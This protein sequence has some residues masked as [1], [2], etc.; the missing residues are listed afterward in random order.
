MQLSFLLTAIG[1]ALLVIS[2]IM[3]LWLRMHTNDLTGERTPAVLATQRAQ[4]GLQRSLASLRGW[5]ALGG[6]RFRAE[7]RQAWSQ[8]IE[9]AFAEIQQFS[10]S[11][12]EPS[13]RERLAAIS[14]PL[15][16]LKE[17]QWWVE[18][19]AQT[20]GNQPAMELL[21]RR[22]Q[23]ISDPLWVLIDDLATESDLKQPARSRVLALQDLA[24]FRRDFQIADDSLSRFVAVDEARLE[25]AFESAISRAE[26]SLE[27]LVNRSSESLGL[28]RDQATYLLQEFHWYKAFAR[29]AIEARRGEAWNVA[30]YRMKTETIP[31][32]VEVTEL[33]STLANSQAEMMRSDTQFVTLAGNT[34]IIL[35]LALILIMA[36]LAYALASYRSDQ[37][38]QPISRLSRATMELAEGRLRRDLPITTDDELGTLT[39]SFNQM[40]V[41]LQESEAALNQANI[42]L[43]DANQDLERHNRFVRSTFGRYLSDDIVANLLD[44]PDGLEI[45]GESRCVTILMADLRGFT[46]LAERLAPEQVVSILN[47]YLGTMVDVITEYGG[48]IDEFLGDAILVIFGAPV[49]TDDHPQRAVAC[50]FA[51]QL[52]MTTV[53]ERNYRDDLP[54]IEMGVG[55]NTGNVVVGNI[56]SETRAKY[57]VVGSPVN[58]TSRIESFTTGGQILISEATKQAVGPILQLGEKLEI[59]AKGINEPV[60][61]HFVR[62]IGGSWNLHLPERGEALI[63]LAQEIP[64]RF[65]VLKGKHLGGPLY[66]GKL[67]RLS[68]R[69]GEFHSDQSV[70][71]LSD[72]KFEVLDRN[73]SN[74]LGELYAKV[75]GPSSETQAG[76]S[77]VFTSISP[78]LTSLFEHLIGSSFEGSTL[79]DEV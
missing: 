42:D 55:V 75:I 29:R 30:L 1:A 60:T 67:V 63:R 16:E 3:V 43:S 47:H 19:V 78:E 2:T 59:E 52:A 69:S 61:V 32:T 50:A 40:R 64:V 25:R 18:D 73:G 12:T 21:R 57:G 49:R 15:V 71:P 5:V 22:V 17:S 28:S 56:G 65:A 70:A 13:D 34:A 31:L 10:K 8:Q 79:R 33:L 38:T 24:G 35:S 72:L 77:A 74:V 58:I 46:S 66:A 11:W 37:I 44:T 23:P 68:M 20:E 14:Q 45:G 27:G 48:T 7:R 54:E 51:M 39:N 26:S 9:P 76:F 62:S 6:V 41:K 53:N 4:I 36:T